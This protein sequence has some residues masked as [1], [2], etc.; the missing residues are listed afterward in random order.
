MPAT[1]KGHSLYNDP[2]FLKLAVEYAERT[3]PAMPSPA[4]IDD[5]GGH[6][7]VLELVPFREK[8]AVEQVA[9]RLHLATYLPMR[10]ERRCDSRGQH[11]VSR[12]A[13]FVGYGFVLAKRIARHWD[14]IKACYGVR[15]IMTIT[16][17]HADVAIPAIVDWDFIRFIQSQE[18]SND[19]LLAADLQAQ[20]DRLS[21]EW[22]KAGRLKRR[23]LRAP[24]RR[25]PE[26]LIEIEP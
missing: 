13:L 3:M 25:E 4:G 5:V 2:E 19:H 10:R 21:Q 26:P 6:W 24:E 23:R 14:A 16:G 1:T 22:R 18:N 12:R 15:G 7:Y 11:F 8:L 9:D 20:Q 17:D